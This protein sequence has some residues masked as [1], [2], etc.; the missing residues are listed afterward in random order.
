MIE[1][2]KNK[3]FSDFCMLCNL[4]L[5]KINKFEFSTF[6][7]KRFEKWYHRI[8]F[9]IRRRKKTYNI[10]KWSWE[11]VTSEFTRVYPVSQFLD[12]QNYKW[13]Y[14][15]KK[16]LVFA[17]NLVFYIFFNFKLNNCIMHKDYYY[18]TIKLANF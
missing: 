17:R 6:L 12:S 13:K 1:N 8:N 14:E 9:C 15:S 4:L 2:S 16:I 11:K 18:L 5:G 7:Q 10:S 3:M